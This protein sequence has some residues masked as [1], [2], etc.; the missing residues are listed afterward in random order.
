MLISKVKACQFAQVHFIHF[1]LNM[2]FLN[3][4]SKSNFCHG[5]F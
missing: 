5:F 3:P 2:D 4:L 1:V